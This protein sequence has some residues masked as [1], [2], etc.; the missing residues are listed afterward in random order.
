M[1]GTLLVATTNPGKLR[2]VRA[3]LAGQAITVR[4]L[5]DF[6]GT[7]EAPEHGLTFEENARSKAA[8]YAMHTGVCTLADDSGLE[9]DALGG[10]PG[11]RSARFAGPDADDDANNAKLIRSLEGISQARRTARFR[12][13]MALATPNAVVAVSEGRIE[14]VVLE[15]PRG[16]N[17]FGYD[18]FFLVPDY[19]MTAAEMPPDL[20]NRVSHRGQA[21]QAILP[22]VIRILAAGGSI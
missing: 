19:G 15:R 5:E 1:A 12:C 16:S 3:L 11:V 20:K 21:L 2:E 8:F 18:P 7:G 4:S 6:P 22:A 9:V 13:A 17:G 14:G 10:E